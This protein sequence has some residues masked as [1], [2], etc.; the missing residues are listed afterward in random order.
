MPDK[1]KTLIFSTGP[2]LWRAHAYP[3]FI[4]GCSFDGGVTDAFQPITSL[5]YGLADWMGCSVFNTR[6]PIMVANIARSLS[7]LRVCGH[8]CYPGLPHVWAEMLL[9]LLEQH[10]FHY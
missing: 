2:D 6:Y 10:H 9:R 7:N 8:F 3:A 4:D 1:Y 5:S